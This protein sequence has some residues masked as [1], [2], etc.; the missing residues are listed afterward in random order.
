MGRNKKGT[1]QRAK[2]IGVIGLVIAAIVGV[3]APGGAQWL[4]YPTAG[5]P[6]TAGGKP[7]L[8][9]PAPRLPD[10][11]PDFS[12]IWHAG[13][14]VPCTPEI[15][16]FIDCGSEIGGSKLTMNLGLDLPGG[17]L[18]YQPWAASETKRRTEDD[19]RDDPHVRCLPDT[20]PRMW[21]LPHLTKAV[22]TPKLLVLLYEVNAMYRQIFID[23]RPFPQDP[24]PAWNGYSVAHWEGGTLVVE[25]R[26]FRD[27][28]WIDMHGSPMSDAA[29]MTERIRRP[30]FGTLEIALTIDDPKA[31]TKTFTVNLT[32]NLEADTELVD[33]FCLEGEKSYQR[34]QRSRGK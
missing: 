4:K 7:N 32:Q 29:K 20:V 11:K 2:G 21:T 27:N 30:N 28:L 16:R 22:H 34:M 12:G 18:P 6:R 14:R 19:S 13:N 5:V 3:S 33:E 1:E 31:Y 24:T 15:S 26:G 8:K 25:T 23:G 17:T 9:A 10:G